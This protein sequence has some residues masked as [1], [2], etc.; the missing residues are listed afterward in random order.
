M[1]ENKDESKELEEIRNRHRVEKKELQSKIQSLKKTTSKGDKKKK[2]EVADMIAQ[3][4]KDLENKQ[5]EEIDKFLDVKSNLDV[6]EQISCNDNETEIEQEKSIPRL[7]RAQK[8]RNKKQ[9]E[10]QEREKRIQEQEEVNKLGPRAMEL[11]SIEQILKSQGLEMY[12]IPADGNCLYY[13]INHQLEITGRDTLTISKLRKLTANYMRDNKDDFM[14]FMYTPNE[15]PMTE[16][17][18]EKYCND[19]EKT[20]MWG[21]QL[22]IKALSSTLKCP[23]KVIQGNGPIALQGENYE[24]P[25]L[26]LT[27]HRY[28]YRLGAHY[29]STI[30][31]LNKINDFHD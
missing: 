29:N 15:D 18:F 26:I 2:K 24:G 20:K 23:I 19:V 25:P 30:L 4:E 17:L 1:N 16:E 7:S 14:P 3:L 22:E 31:N 9:H 10:Q 28:L 5:A 11:Q 8:R 27:Y 6:I 21:S 13:A 12:N